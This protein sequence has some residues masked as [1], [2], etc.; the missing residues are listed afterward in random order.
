[1][2][3]NFQLQNARTSVIKVETAM[4]GR[5]IPLCGQVFGE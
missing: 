4:C 2:K 5:Q 1:M 3:E